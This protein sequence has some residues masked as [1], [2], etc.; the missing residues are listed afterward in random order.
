MTQLI[1]KSKFEM[2]K[3][4]GLIWHMSQ[5]RKLRTERFWVQ[6]P[7]EART[8]VKYF[9]SFYLVALEPMGVFAANKH[10]NKWYQK[11]RR[12]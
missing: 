6:S 12:R 10:E 1:L 7:T 8:I 9:L 4:N 2:K 5:G 3:I 11:R